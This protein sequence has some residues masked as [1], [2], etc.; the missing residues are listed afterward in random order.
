MVKLG[1]LVDPYAQPERLG[2]DAAWSEG[3][4]WLP[5]EDAVIWS[6]IPGNRILRWSAGTGAVTV[7]RTGVEFTNGR[8]LDRDGQVVTCSHGRRAIEG[9]PA[10]EP[11]EVLV[12]R[13]GAARLNS[14]NDVVVAADG[15]IWF[16]DPPYG[17]VQPHEG[18]PGEREYGDCYVFR[19]DP[20]TGELA[21]AVLDVEEPNGL[22]FSPDGSLLYVTDTSAALRTDGTGNHWI[23]VYDVVDGRR[24]K[25]GRVFAEVTPGLADGIKVDVDGNV[26]TSSADSI[27]VYA[28]DGTR[29]GKIPVPE[30]VG[31]LCF[32]G[33]DGD[34]LFIAAGTG[35][36]RLPTRTQ[37]AAR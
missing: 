21:P 14:P 9:G 1:D 24:C 26:W 22:A 5:G 27:Q 28:P 30:K 32:G 4:L 15:A 18:H 37:G 16:T 12:D 2:G 20:A 3:P 6:D 25:N 33:P 19:F 29:L 10:G 8:C 23:R 7:D 17:I 13:F 35:L 11:G 36:Y 34:V 31:N